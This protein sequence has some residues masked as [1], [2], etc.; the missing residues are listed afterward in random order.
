MK[1]LTKKERLNEEDYDDIVEEAVKL[2]E[3]NAVKT[4]DSIGLHVVF[5]PALYDF[6]VEFKLVV[7]ETLGELATKIAMGDD[8]EGTMQ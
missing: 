5:N 4:E 3:V 6:P 2:I 8:G 1:Y 7:I